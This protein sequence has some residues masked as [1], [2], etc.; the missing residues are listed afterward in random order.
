MRKT[1]SVCADYK[2]IAYVYGDY[3]LDLR[4]SEFIRYTSTRTWFIQSDHLIMSTVILIEYTD[5]WRTEFNR[6]AA[7]VAT[8]LAGDDYSIEHIG[9][10][11]VQGL[12]AK[13]VIDVLV[14]VASLDVIANRTSELQTIGFRYR[15]EYESQ[16]PLRR[17][18]V[19]DSTSAMRVHLHGVLL[20]GKLWKEHLAFREALRSDLILASQYST[21]KRALAVQYAND[22][23]GYTQAKSPFIQAVLRDHL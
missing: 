10:T 11:S 21:L 8:A 16:I 14:G 2:E 13:P 9:S 17:Y 7:D 12:C 18:F 19:R 1:A 20:G 5:F 6:I 4:R 15:P 3:N 23:A 22:K